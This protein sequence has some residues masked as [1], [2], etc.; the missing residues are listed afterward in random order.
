MGK[1]RYKNAFRDRG[2]NKG[3]NKRK[4]QERKYMFKFNTVNKSKLQL[5]SYN[6]VLKIVL[7]SL[8]NIYKIL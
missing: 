2:K 5:K 7:E 6:T 3:K 8:H 4:K 1:G